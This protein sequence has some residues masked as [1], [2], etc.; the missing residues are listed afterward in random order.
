MSQGTLE[1]VSDS[2][3]QMKV[4]KPRIINGDAEAKKWSEKMMTVDCLRKRLASERTASKAAKENAQVMEEKLT[5][6]EKLLKMEIEAKERA[7]KKLKLAMKKLKNLKLTPCL[8]QSDT[9]EDRDSSPPPRTG[10]TEE[11]G[12]VTDLST[13]QDSEA[14][15]SEN[16]HNIFV[17]QVT[18]QEGRSSSV[19][20][21][22]FDNTE[23]PSKDDGGKV[24]A[25]DVPRL[26]PT[27]G[28]NDLDRREETEEVDN[29]L[30]LVLVPELKKCLEHSPALVVQQGVPPFCQ[31]CGDSAPRTKDIYEVLVALQ[32]AKAHLQSSIET[33]AA[34]YSSHSFELC[35]I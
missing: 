4:E 26:C 17:N 20:T 14:N 22:P 34:V 24:T 33:R 5:E 29:S 8:S 27:G 21:R 2:E 15:I 10:M 1:W 32:R 3:G 35:G 13:S 16:S 30:A 23:G 6:L 9:T 28:E 12:E 19:E 18:S 11:R 7:E 31:N 25:S